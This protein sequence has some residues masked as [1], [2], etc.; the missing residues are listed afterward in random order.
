MAYKKSAQY[1]GDGGNAFDDNLTQVQK[2]VSIRIRHGARVDALQT[3]WRLTDGSLLS[4]AQHGAD[5]G[6]ESVIQF[7]EDEYLLTVQGRSGSRVDAL[8]FTTNKRTYGPYGGDGGKPFGPIAAERAVG[9]FGRSAAEL[10]AFGVF[11]HA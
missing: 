1:G 5:G 3:T 6:G 7:D 8:S 2:I 11:I 10:D 4:S 9:F